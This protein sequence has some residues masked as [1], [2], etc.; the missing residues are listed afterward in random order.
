VGSQERL[1]PS[2]VWGSGRPPGSFWNLSFVL[3][4]TLKLN[5]VSMVLGGDWHGRR[6]VT[7][8]FLAT[9]AQI[10]QVALEASGGSNLPPTIYPSSVNWGRPP[11]FIRLFVAVWGFV[12]PTTNIFCLP[13]SG[14]DNNDYSACLWSLARLYLTKLRLCLWFIIIFIFQ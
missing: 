9:F 2:H 13:N 1:S 11:S 3:A 4:D 14:F 8:K 6:E 7:R 5:W 12:V 10:S